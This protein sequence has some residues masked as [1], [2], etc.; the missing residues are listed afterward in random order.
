MQENRGECFVW[1]SQWNTVDKEHFRR[2]QTEIKKIYLFPIEIIFAL[3]LAVWPA[4]I[5]PRLSYSYCYLLSSRTAACQS[6]SVSPAGLS[7]GPGCCQSPPLLHTCVVKHYY[8]LVWRAVNGSLLGS[9]R[10]VCWCRDRK[11]RC[12]VCNFSTRTTETPGSL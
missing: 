10:R 6:C 9:R 8:F 11:C 5:S 1:L 4:N 12:T 3:F 2:K 7:A